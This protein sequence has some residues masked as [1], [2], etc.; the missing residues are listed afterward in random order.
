MPALDLR[1][2]EIIFWFHK[3]G[4]SGQ[5]ELSRCLARNTNKKIR[6]RP[7]LA[8]SSCGENLETQEGQTGVEFGVDS[9]YHPDSFFTFLGGQSGLRAHEWV[10]FDTQF[11]NLFRSNGVKS[12]HAFP[13]GRH[14]LSIHSFPC[15]KTGTCATMLDLN[16]S[17]K[18]ITRGVTRL[19]TPT[20]KGCSAVSCWFPWCSIFVRSR[21]ICMDHACLL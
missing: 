14:H 11:F 2:G 7:G 9:A 12:N 16:C 21:R 15:C 8:V 4:N 3:D 6:G 13:Y 5:G 17:T 10:P 1:G 19:S 18:H 20:L